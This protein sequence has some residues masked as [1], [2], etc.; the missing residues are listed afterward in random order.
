MNASYRL[1]IIILGKNTGIIFTWSNTN[2]NNRKKIIVAIEYLAGWMA[3]KYRF[4]LTDTIST[5]NQLNTIFIGHDF[6]TI[7]DQPFIIH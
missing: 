4:V 5:K 6:N 7:M 2:H 1:K 3:K